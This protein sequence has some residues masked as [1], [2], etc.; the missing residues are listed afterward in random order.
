MEAA[1]AVKATP[2]QLAEQ[3]T[4]L[5]EE[6]RKL[7]REVRDLRRKL[8]SGE[9]AA[10]GGNKTVAGVTYAARVLDGVPAGEPRVWPIRSRRT[11]ARAWCP[12]S[13]RG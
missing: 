8:A 6:R 5:V 11:S 2:E 9:G 1:A 3:V 13:R 10:A 7:E 12:S 4:S